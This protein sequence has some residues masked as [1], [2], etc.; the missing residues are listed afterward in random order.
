M[1]TKSN[2]HF[3]NRSGAVEI[4]VPVGDATLES[5]VNVPQ[6]YWASLLRGGSSASALTPDG[7]ADLGGGG[8]FHGARV[9]VERIG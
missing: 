8:F 3:L 7:L 1:S 4:A 6:G 5:V 9:E 2:R